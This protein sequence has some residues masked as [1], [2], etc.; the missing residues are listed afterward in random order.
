MRILFFGTPSFSVPTLDLLLGQNHRVEAVFT[1]PDRPRGRGQKPAAS[2]VK[3]WAEGHGIPAHQPETLDD[4]TRELVQQLD[5]DVAVVVA[6]GLILPG[7]L[8][9]LPHRGAV[10]VHASLLPKYRGAAPIPWAIIRGEE[11]T[12]V[13][14][15][16]M[17]EGVDTGPILL[18]ESEPI[19][20][21]D[22]AADLEARLSILGAELL[23]KA[24]DGIERG[25]ITPKPQDP[26]G[27]SRAPRLKKGDGRISWD[28]PAR[29]IHNLAR[30]LNPWPG[31]FALFRGETVKVWYT[32]PAEVVPKY[33]Q[34]PGTSG[35]ILA[36]EAEALVVQCEGGSFLKIQELQV[37]DRKRW[38]GREFL[39]GLR[40][41]LGDKFQ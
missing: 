33:S 11:V 27:A 10:N 2:P 36:L 28:R 3:V 25:T 15:I 37:A 7:W 17:D 20:A 6:Y 5:P 13:T 21:L 24:L 38:S 8:L 14:T 22:T 41:K 1:Q 18:Q 30:G 9:K 40:A 19:R 35:E 26:R 4:R 29:E 12:G 16:L 31:A 39:N 34:K 23:V 32:T